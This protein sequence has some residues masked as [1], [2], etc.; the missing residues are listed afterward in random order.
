MQEL[1]K[2]TKLFSFSSDDLIKWIDERSTWSDFK[3]GEYL[4]HE[5]EKA[6]KMYVIASG[7]VKV[8]KEFA[9]GKNAILGL[10]S[11]GS[12]VAEVTVIDRKPY[13]A[14]AVAMEDTHA[15]GIPADVLREAIG[16]FPELSIRIIEGLGAK[17][18]ELTTTMGSLSTQKV[19][20]RLAR[21][22]YKFGHEIGE[23]RSDGIHLA[24][25]MTRRDL[26]EII[27]TS[28][29]VVERALKKMREEGILKIDAK[30]ILICDSQRLKDLFH[31]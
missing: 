19:E 29:E 7:R 10:F 18:R 30:N 3:K 16:K 5:G 8:V 12:I 21:F 9:S 23:K 2:A 4:F 31:E 15:G 6:E 14:S 11:R 26:A 1:L 20:K 25:P 27:G 13:P 17:L 28:F 24:L 22:L